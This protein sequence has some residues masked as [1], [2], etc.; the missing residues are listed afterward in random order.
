M[1]SQQSCSGDTGFS[2]TPLSGP[3]RYVKGVG[4]RVASLLAKIDIFTVEDLLYFFP[5]RY[6]DRRNL[7]QLD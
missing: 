7:L 2:T 5:Y 6:E 3:V 1:P 4:E